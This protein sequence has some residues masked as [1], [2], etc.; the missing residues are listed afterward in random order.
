[1]NHRNS[2]PAGYFSGWGRSREARNVST[3]LATGGSR[4]VLPVPGPEAVRKVR[5]AR[6]VSACLTTPLATGGSRSVP[7]RTRGREARSAVP[8]SRSGSNRRQPLCAAP[9]PGPGFTLVELLVVIA[10]IGM[11]VGLLLPAVQQAREAARQMQC[12]NNLRQLGLACLN[13][14]SS[15]K[16]LPSSGWLWQWEGDPDLGFR[17]QCGSWAY[18]LLPFV[19]QQAMWALGQD[20]IWDINDVQ[21]QGALE[22]MQ[23]P[24]ATFYC[25]SR[26]QAI[27]Y[28][29]NQ[30]TCHN[31]NR[32]EA[33]VSGKN[34]YAGNTGDTYNVWYGNYSTIRSGYNTD[35]TPGTYE[36]GTIYPRSFV[37]L[38]EIRDGTSNTY[39]IGEKYLRADKYTDGTEDGDD[40]SAWMGADNDRLRKC[41]YNASGQYRPLQD[42]VGL[43][44][45]LVFGSAHAG[46]FGMVL[47]DGSVHRVGYSIDAL[48]HS[49]LGKKA[50]GKVATLPE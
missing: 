36:T 38:S 12:N 24:V 39:L 34:D 20:G 15:Q 22:R 6:S 50:D 28:P 45:T 49:Y 44:N 5:E 13:H 16:A 37:S 21:K 11:L 30:Q 26:R 23:M 40:H 47:C 48:V 17:Y 27:A 35:R 18:S 10:I 43:S 42:R 25:P 8:A 14:E 3:P 4:S 19:E 41:Y 1:M 9:H 29:L 31:G 33:T 7:P 32:G 46:S 2:N